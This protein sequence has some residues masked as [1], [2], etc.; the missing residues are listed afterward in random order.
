MK[1]LSYVNRECCH[2]CTDLLGNLIEMLVPPAPAFN[3]LQSV[4]KTL[5]V[6]FTK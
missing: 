2:L 6:T 4:E 5:I 3:A 1:K